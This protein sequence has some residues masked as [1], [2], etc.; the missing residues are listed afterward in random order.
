[1]NRKKNGYRKNVKKAAL[2]LIVG[3]LSVFCLTGCSTKEKMTAKTP[4]SQSQQEN[5]GS[6]KK[7]GSENKNGKKSG[8]KK[9]KDKKTGGK[10]SGS[11]VFNDNPFTTGQ[12]TKQQTAEKPAAGS[13][14]TKQQTAG[15]SPADSQPTKKQTIDNPTADNRKTNGNSESKVSE[16]KP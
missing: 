6:K 7:S 12:T 10:K 15:K 16:K 5:A 1:M 14:T 9:K 3:I 11:I 13:E 8:N 4:N 2:I